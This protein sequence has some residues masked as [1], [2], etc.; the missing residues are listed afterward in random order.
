[1][2]VADMSSAHLWRLSDVYRF[3]VC[4]R[5]LK[6]NN[7]LDSCIHKGKYIN[8]QILAEHFS[9]FLSS[10]REAQFN[11]HNLAWHARNK[12]TP[13]FVQVL[14]HFQWRRQVSA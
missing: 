2:Y 14:K 6:A 11:L 13:P 10:V 3:C 4:L 8:K 5:S 9:N 12:R 7:S 1:M